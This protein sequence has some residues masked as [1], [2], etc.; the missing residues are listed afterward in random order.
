MI[1]ANIKREIPEFVH[2]YL[3]FVD[4]FVDAQRQ[5][6]FWVFTKNLKFFEFYR[7]TL[8]AS[9]NLT[10]TC[11]KNVKDQLMDFKGPKCRSYDENSV[12]NSSNICIGKYIFHTL[13]ALKVYVIIK[14]WDKCVVIQRLPN[15]G[16]YTIIG[17]YENLHS[18]RIAHGPVKYS[19][20]LELEFTSG[21]ILKCDFEKEEIDENDFENQRSELKQLLDRIR[22]SKSELKLHENITAQSFDRLQD[23]LT[24]G[25]SYVRS[26]K[27]E[28]KQML[29]RCGD[30]WK[31]LTPQ[32]DLVIGIPLVNQCSAP[33][34]T[35]LHNIQ[36]LLD[37]GSQSEESSVSIKYR[38]YQLKIPFYDLDSIETFLQSEDEQIQLNTW[39]SSRKCQLLPESFGI[40]VMKF[41]VYDVINL[42]QCPILL[43]YDV[44]KDYHST[45]TSTPLQIY[46]GTL[47]F[48]DI[49]YNQHTNYELNFKANTLHQDFLAT[50]MSSL[51]INLKIT[52]QYHSDLDIFERCLEE[53]F[54]YEKLPVI[55]ENIL[56]HTT[57]YNHTQNSQWYGYLCL[58]SKETEEDENDYSITFWRFY[59]P[60][61][62]NAVVFMK[63]LLNDLVM[64][65]CNI[66]SIKSVAKCSAETQ[67][68]G[69]FENALREELKNYMQLYKEKKCDANFEEKSK[70]FVEFYKTQLNS[71]KIFQHI[72]MEKENT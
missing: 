2:H 24:Y 25:L 51:E 54:Q 29:A 6:T 45:I 65:K 68:V 49:L 4:C 58:R 41:K 70:L 27:L 50:A 20:M 55:T 12:L 52:F 56:H 13:N 47:D 10:N 37:I 23:R 42:K 34:L 63:L 64:L 53:K 48:H 1:P 57:F 32:N 7:K 60:T 15:F 71:D 5:K 28:E 31:K 43:H 67:H 11:L 3:A 44:S 21:S 16:G 18:F 17:E 61:V 69:E 66:I 72:K 46:L 40:L 26:L 38:L 19:S 30:I 36:P 9:I 14:C 62:E 22:S 33:N 8:V 39:S 35:I 59:V